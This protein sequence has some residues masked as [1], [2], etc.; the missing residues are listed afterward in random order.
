VGEDHHETGLTEP[1]ERETH[2]G[3]RADSEQSDTSRQPYRRVVRGMG[4]G[5]E[6]I[7]APVSSLTITAN[8]I[9][10]YKMR[11]GRR[12]REGRRGKG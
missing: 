10:T 5:E 12:E 11:E 2:E 7:C 9:G 4:R 3:A 8:H 6:E 1:G